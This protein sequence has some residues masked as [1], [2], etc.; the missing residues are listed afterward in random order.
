MRNADK[1]AMPLADPEVWEDPSDPSKGTTA[2]TGLTKREHF[3]AMAMQGMMANEDA[4][5]RMAE[6]ANE[7]MVGPNYLMASACVTIADALL[8]ELEQKS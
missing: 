5:R 4:L 1:P 6:G 8:A 7:E 2:A 3:A